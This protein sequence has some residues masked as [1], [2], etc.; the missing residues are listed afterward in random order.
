MTEVAP[1]GG[2]AGQLLP[3]DVILAV[4][5]VQVWN[6]GSTLALRDKEMIDFSYLI[7]SRMKRATSLKILRGGGNACTFL[8]FGWTVRQMKNE[9]CCNLTCT[10]VS[11]HRVCSAQF[12][13][14]LIASQHI[15]YV[16]GLCFAR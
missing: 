10:G 3:R 1:L 14:K 11:V 4:D 15:S 13:M 2:W 5:D 12:I 16:E 7:T 9:C 6:D 8:N